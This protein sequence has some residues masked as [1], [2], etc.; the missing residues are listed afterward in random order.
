MWIQDSVQRPAWPN[1]RADEEFIRSFGLVRQRWRGGLRGWVGENYL[2]IADRVL[3][4]PHTPESALLFKQY[5]FRIVFRTFYFDGAAVGKLEIGIAEKRNASEETPI[6]E[7]VKAFL[8]LPVY[9]PDSLTKIPYQG[10]LL[11][12]GKALARQYL[13]ATTPKARYQDAADNDWWVESGPPVLLVERVQDEAWTF[14]EDARETYAASGDWPKV[15]HHLVQHGG[16]RVNL[17]ACTSDSW[18]DLSSPQVKVKQKALREMRISLMRIHTER[19]CMLNVIRA[20]EQ[21]RIAVTPRGPADDRLQRYLRDASK[22]ILKQEAAT[23]IPAVA[24]ANQFD[25]MATPGVRDAMLASLEGMRPFVQRLVGAVVSA[26]VTLTA[27]QRKQLYEALIAAFDADGLAMMVRLELGERLDVIV[28]GGPLA[29][30]VFGLIGWAERTGSTT[31]LIA[32]ALKADPGNPELSAFAAEM[33][34]DPP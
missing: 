16:R 29:N 7:I 27:A 18:A 13:A 15:E 3:R 28:G 4:V 9:V 19:E 33:G 32:A 25:D 10:P 26:Q 2:C 31:N 23:S 6:W 24:Q 14:D 21:T 30:V 22:R 11:N 1:P 34:I 17:W 12:A 8:S 20:V 5:Q